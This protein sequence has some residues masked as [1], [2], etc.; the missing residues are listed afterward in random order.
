MQ[1]LHLNRRTNL[2]G[3]WPGSIESLNA[4]N[5]S[6]SLLQVYDPTNIG[7]FPVVALFNHE[8]RAY[9]YTSESSQSSFPFDFNPFHLRAMT[10]STNGARWQEQRTALLASRSHQLILTKKS[11]IGDIVEGPYLHSFVLLLIFSPE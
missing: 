6:Y 11:L 4:S 2:D 5:H 10:L 8:R 7:M 3:F 9:S 1:E